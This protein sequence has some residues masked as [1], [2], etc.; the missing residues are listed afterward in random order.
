MARGIVTSKP[1]GGTTGNTAGRI[2]T[3]DTKSISSSDASGA[4]TASYELGSEVEFLKDTTA[5]VGDLVDF[6]AD[7]S[8]QVFVNS[9]VTAGKVINGSTDNIVVSG[10][11]PILI[12]GTVD[13]KVTVSGGIAVIDSAKLSGK[14]ESADG[15]SYILTVDSTISGKVE[16]TGASYLSLKN[17][18][19]EGKVSSDGS[20][21]TTVRKCE[22][23]GS[24]EVINTVECH[25]SDNSVDGKTNTPNNQP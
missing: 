3:T 7:S 24:L 21:Y 18:T 14:L 4:A 13:G 25:C 10:A 9:V 12:T 17:S 11:A 15:K 6:S 23:E 2:I 5:N 1:T 20:L 8:G 22:I 16:I 19:I